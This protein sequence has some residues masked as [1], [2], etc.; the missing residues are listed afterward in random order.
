MASTPV[1]FTCYVPGCTKA[2]QDIYSVSRHFPTEHPSLKWDLQ[3]A[4]V[5]NNLVEMDVESS[6]GGRPQREKKP[7]EK[8]KDATAKPEKIDDGKNYIVPFNFLPASND[9][10]YNLPPNEIPKFFDH[11]KTSAITGETLD[12]YK[13]GSQ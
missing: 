13:L 6:V 12:F 5:H 9:P 4:K 8:V 10:K 2:R 3:Q 11:T 1:K 7:T